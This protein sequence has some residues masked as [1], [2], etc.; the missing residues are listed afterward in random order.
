MKK[1]RL[2]LSYVE[3]GVFYPTV[4]SLSQGRFD[5]LILLP[6]AHTSFKEG[7]LFIS[8]TEL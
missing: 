2:I 6:I 5:V 1:L 8:V 7:N 4:Y 3:Q